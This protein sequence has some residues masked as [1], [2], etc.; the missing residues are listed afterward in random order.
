[1]SESTDL[2]YYQRNRDA[3][4]NRANDYYKNDKE[5]F[6]KQARDKYRNLYEEEEEKNEKWKYGRN[7]YHKKSEEMKQNTKRIPKKLPWG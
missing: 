7:S 3:I 6:R 2:T 5:I 4:L 1:M